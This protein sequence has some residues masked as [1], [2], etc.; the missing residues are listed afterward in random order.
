[1]K[2]GPEIVRRSVEWLGGRVEL[3]RFDYSRPHAYEFSYEHG[4]GGAFTLKG[5]AEITNRRI[6]GRAAPRGPSREGELNFIRIGSTITGK[7]RGKLEV[8]QLL[9]D[10]CFLQ[11]NGDLD[12]VNSASVPWLSTLSDPR[13]QYL[14]QELASHLEHSSK[15]RPLM[16]NGAASL[17][18]FR[19]LQLISATDISSRSTAQ[20]SFSRLQ[21]ALDYIESNLG[22]KMMLSELAA[23]VGLSA[24][25]FC[26]AFRH[27]T[28]LSPHR[29]VVARRIERAKAL[30][31][32]NDVD[33]AEVA[34]AV[35][36]NS[37]SH[38][39]Q[40]FRKAIGVTPLH[41]SR[42]L[43]SRRL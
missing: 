42:Q 31:C 14:A 17:M 28:G 39:S 25:W 26:H 29:Y 19:L 33:I 32:G 16:V 38:F 24:A 18:T 5:C 41:Y 30:L 8:L 6:D 37:Q 10:P 27:S 1:M 36:F 34:L 15:I 22:R 4:F 40:A 11:A 43:R 35:G 3:V 23:R 21:A 9:I 12:V 7:V 13:T 2:L 20:L